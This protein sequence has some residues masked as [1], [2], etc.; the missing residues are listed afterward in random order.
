LKAGSTI[1]GMNRLL[2]Q[3]QG[4]K[5]PDGFFIVPSRIPVAF[6]A[7][8]LRPRPYLTSAAVRLLNAKERHIVAAHEQEHVR[9]RDPLKL[10]LL[11][12]SGLLFPGFRLIEEKWKS[13]AEVECDSASLQSGARP[14]EVSLTIVKLARAVGSHTHVPALAYAV[15]TESDLRRRVGSL[16]SGVQPPEQKL[17][18][19]PLVLL[20]L[21]LVSIGSSRAHHVLETVLGQLM[22]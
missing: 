7:G 13:A 20:A 1:F 14:E 16:L 21:A 3:S 5:R 9:R 19:V 10:L 15:G 22:R 6:A 2:R 18:W 8:I 4:T 17:P 12:I 11:R